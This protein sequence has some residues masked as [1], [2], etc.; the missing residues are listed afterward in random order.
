[1]LLHKQLHH[2]RANEIPQTY[3]MGE[4]KLNVIASNMLGFKQT[5]IVVI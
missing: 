2:F 1:M 3:Y 4:Q 5:Y